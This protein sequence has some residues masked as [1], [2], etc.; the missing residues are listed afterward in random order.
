MCV[1]PFSH[2]TINIFNRFFVRRYHN[3]KIMSITDSELEQQF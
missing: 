2:A 3:L 1:A